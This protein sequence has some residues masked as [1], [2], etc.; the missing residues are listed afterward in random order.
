MKKVQDYYFKKAKQ[1]GYVARSVFKLQ[2][3]NQK[4]RLIEAGDHVLDLGCCPGSWMQYTSDI[5]GEKGLVVGIDLKTLELPLKA[6]MRFIQADIFSLDRETLGRFSRAFDGVCSD[7]APNTT[8]IR[9]LDAER[10]FQLCR[11]ALQIAD[12]W[13][14]PGGNLLVKIFQGVAF[15]GLLPLVRQSYQ[16]LKIIKPKSSRNESTEVYV[17]GTGK[18]TTAPPAP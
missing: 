7:M 17:L 3:I 16:S 18:K 13:L 15:E 5:V 9:S 6:N 12:E 14:K 10:S 4:H 1:Q 11:Q 2:E 8:G